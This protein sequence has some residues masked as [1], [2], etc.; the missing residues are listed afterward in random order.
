MPGFPSGTVPGGCPNGRRFGDDVID[1]AVTAVLSDLR[2]DPLVINGPAGDGLDS[3]DAAY[4]RVFP[5]AGTPLNGRKHSHD[6]VLN[7]SVL[8]FA[9]F[10]NGDGFTSDIVLTNPSTED[11]VL[12]SIVFSDEEG[13]ALPVGI[14]AGPGIVP[15]DG[16]RAQD[17]GSSRVDF[18]IPIQG[19]ITISTDGLG[20]LIQGAVRV[21]AQGP[22]G[23]VIRFQIPGIGI[24]GVQISELTTGFSAPARRTPEGFQTGLAIRNVETDPIDLN[25]SLPNRDGEEIASSFIE[26]FP[27]GGHPARFVDE[28]F[29]SLGKSV[30]EGSVRVEADGGRI[31]AMALELGPEPGQFTTLPIIPLP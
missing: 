12:G 16:F 29:E 3:N 28:L 31:A 18:S 4:N 15:A 23:G 14:A 2:S 6:S 26:S 5:Y 17:H 20:E 24:A 9:H 30:F 27:A 13:A 10:G 8:E 22:L 21:T 19:S 7:A 25:L 1:I 11:S